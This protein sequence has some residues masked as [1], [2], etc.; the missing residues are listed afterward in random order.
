VGKSSIV[1]ALTGEQ[2]FRTAEVRES[3]SRGRHTTTH[4]ELILLPEGGAL[5]DTPGMREL[6]LWAGEDALD[7]VFDE[8]AALAAA[9]RFSDC[10]HTVEHSCAVQQA[11]AAGT[12]S[13]ARWQSYR[14]LRSEVRRHQ[15]LADPLAAQLE[16]RKLRNLH[17]AVKQIYKTRKHRT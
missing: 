10:S 4:R 16:K 11:L 3:D 17:Q 13:E 8:I 9:C 2:H 5:I 14:K 1:N 12:L 6:Q 15:S 7:Q